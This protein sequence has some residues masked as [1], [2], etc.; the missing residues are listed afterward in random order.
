MDPAQTNFQSSPPSDGFSDSA[1]SDDEDDVPADRNPA[2]FPLFVDTRSEGSGLLA[3][4]PYQSVT[5]R[6]RSEY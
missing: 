1:T 2:S 5:W 4:G 3:T 6:V